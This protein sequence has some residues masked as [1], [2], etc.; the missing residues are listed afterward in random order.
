MYKKDKDNIELKVKWL[1]KLFDFEGLF[2]FTDFSNLKYIFSSGYLKS[3][4]DCEQEGVE[5]LDGAN[6]E[7]IDSTNCD[8]KKCVRFYYKE[9]TPML[10]KVEGIKKGDKPHVPV[11]VYL[12]FDEELIYLSSS[13]Y[14][15]GNA[16]SGKSHL[17]SDYNFFLSMDWDSIFH[18]EPLIC[19]DDIKHEI[20][21]KRHAELLCKEPVSKDY[22]KRIIF[23]CEADRKRAVN[24]FGDKPNYEVN[25]NMFNNHHNYIT[26]YKINTNLKNSKLKFSYTF[27]KYSY[28]HYEYLYK[29]R[30]KY[31]RVVKRGRIEYD[32]SDEISLAWEITFRGV[33]S[34]WSKFEF[35]MDD[36]LCVEE[37]L[38]TKE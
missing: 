4:Y 16:R 26:D 5:F 20:L 1:K 9:K 14:S 25:R 24:L 19:D 15:D 37:F 13:Y 11:P 22:I 27:N 31:G 36:I 17:G 38:N 30:N 33:D 18:R 7:I 8:V 34:T 28:G 3:R 23:R 2:H 32:D 6:Q 12:M 21:R 10:Y 29:I 35:Y